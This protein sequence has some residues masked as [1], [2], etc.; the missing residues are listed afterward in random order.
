MV[1]IEEENARHLG[2]EARFD[3]LPGRLLQD[4]ILQEQLWD[5]PDIPASGDTR[6]TMLCSIPL[7]RK[8]SEELSSVWSWGAL[9][10]WFNSILKR[11]A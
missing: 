9:P 8:R 5:H 3:L 2:R 1:Q 4:A 10:L 7:L 11:A 6:L